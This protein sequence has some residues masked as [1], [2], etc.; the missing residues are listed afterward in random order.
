VTLSYGSSLQAAGPGLEAGK[1]LLPFPRLIKI[2]RVLNLQLSKGALLSPRGMAAQ[3]AKSTAA[4][5]KAKK[6]EDKS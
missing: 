3:Q 5:R 2:T 1:M 4:P 6:K